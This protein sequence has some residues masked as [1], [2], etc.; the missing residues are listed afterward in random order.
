MKPVTDKLSQHR[1]FDCELLI[2]GAGPAGLSAAAAAS[3]AGI[4]IILADENAQ[5]GGQIWRGGAAQWRDPRTQPLWQTVQSAAN[6]HCLWQARLVYIERQLAL[7]ETPQGPLTVRWNKLLIATGARELL[8]PFPGWTLPG[9]MGAGGLQ[10]LIKA[11]MPVRGKRIV[12]AGSGPLLL[13]AAMTAKAAGADVLCIAEHQSWSKLA[14]F[15]SGLVWTAPKKAWQALVL[16]WQLRHSPY[17][18]DSRVIAAHGQQALASLTL[19]QGQQ[20]RQVSCDIL[21]CGF[22]LLPNLEIARQLGCATEAWQGFLRGMVD[23]QQRSSQPDIWLAG[24]AC[25]IGGVEQA[26]V[27]GCIAGLAASGQSQAALSPDL[28]DQRRAALAFAELLARYFKPDQRLRQ[29]CQPD[30]LVCRCE[31]VSKQQLQAFQDWRSAKLQ[32]R[33]GMGPCQGRFC[34]S[35]CQVLFDWPPADLRPPVFPAKVSTLCALAAEPAPPM[36]S[37]TQVADKD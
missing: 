32:T 36:S 30:T 19:Q 16:R 2:L 25:G 14:G 15:L 7:F 31:D 35:A 13:A 26:L 21:A 9:V 18:S 11:G 24:E 28:Q 10:A 1:Q 20:Q 23:Q 6:L 22:G 27:Q 37:Q 3:A 12:V 33:L 4:S 8:L 17:L 34:A 29:L 5:P